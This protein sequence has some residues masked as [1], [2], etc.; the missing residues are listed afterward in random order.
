MLLACGVAGMK[1]LPQLMACRQQSNYD[2][3]LLP[4]YLETNTGHLE[5]LE[6]G[7]RGHRVPR[8]KPFCCVQ[9]H[10]DF[11]E[12]L[13]SFYWKGPPDL[14]KARIRGCCRKTPLVLCLIKGI[15]Y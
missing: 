3:W 10:A 15:G 5:G 12:A 2:D 11:L 13:H 4:H 8:E 9:V 1:G 6:A 14:E 7:I